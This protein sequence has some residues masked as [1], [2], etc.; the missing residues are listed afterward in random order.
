MGNTTGGNSILTS[1]DGVNWTGRGTSIFTAYGTSAYYHDGL[2]VAG[3]VGINCLAYSNDGINWTGLGTS[4]MS[5]CFK[6]IYA[7]D[8]W[9]AVGS[10]LS[11]IHI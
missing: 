8:K 2:W 11:L 5:N 4:L 6:V 7:D 9:V 10:G 1:T 3:G